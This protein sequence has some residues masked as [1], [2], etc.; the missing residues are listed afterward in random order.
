[1]CY[2]LPKDDKTAQIRWRNS[3][4]P[5]E[6]TKTVTPRAYAVTQEAMKATSLAASAALAADPIT[7]KA[8]ATPARGAMV[9]G[10][11]KNL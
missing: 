6:T 7:P 8:A 11:A 5:A 10:E 2:S 1:V 9:R 3:A 4:A